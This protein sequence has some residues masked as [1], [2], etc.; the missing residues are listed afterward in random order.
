MRGKLKKAGVRSV[1][2]RFGRVNGSPQTIEWLSDNGSGYIAREARAFAREIGLEPLT[3]PVTSPQANGMA[4]AFV[5]AIKRDYA[6]V[7]PLSDA[8]TAIDSLPFWFEHYNAV[9]QLSALRYRSPREFIAAQS[10]FEA[11]SGI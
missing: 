2:S 10:S 4:E 6:R 9:H 8:R 5:Q 1:E 11:V 3:T 7:N